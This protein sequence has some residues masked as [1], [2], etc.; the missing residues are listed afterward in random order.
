[1]EVDEERGQIWE[2]GLEATWED[3]TEGEDGALNLEKI[4]YAQRHRRR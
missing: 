1:M 3:I 4:L 2:E